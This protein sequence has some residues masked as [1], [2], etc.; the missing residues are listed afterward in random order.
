[1]IHKDILAKK[2]K[3]LFHTKYQEVKYQKQKVAYP[4]Y[5][6]IMILN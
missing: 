4:K 2:D 6:T 5:K 1:M 3:I